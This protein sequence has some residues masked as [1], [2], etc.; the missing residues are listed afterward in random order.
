MSL[1]SFALSEADNKY[2]NVALEAARNAGDRNEVPVGAVVIDG[3]GE[4]LAV[5]GNRTIL[6]SDPTAHAEILALREASKK[7]GNYR[8]TECS[9]YTT[10]EPCVMCAGALVNARVSSLVFGALDERFGAVRTHF[11][12]CD[13][14]LLNHRMEIKGGVLEEECRSLIQEFFRAR[15]S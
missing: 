9:V 5:A 3:G 2:M 1:E 14:E 7:T 8:L 12:L 4:V 11:D 15:R 10:I 6:D 13:S